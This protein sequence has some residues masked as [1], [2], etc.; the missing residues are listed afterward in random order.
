MK[1]QPGQPLPEFS[2]PALDGSTFHTSQLHGNPALINFFRFATCPF[3]NLRLNALLN[4]HPNLPPNFQMIAIFESPID[5]LAKHAPA[6]QSTIPVLANPE[7]DV[8]DLFGVERSVGGMLKGMATR[9]PTLL[10]GV[11]QGHI[12]TTTKGLSRMPAE[13][14]VHPDATLGPVYYGADDGDH[15]PLDTILDFARAAR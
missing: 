14:L 10:K 13:F 1:R 2:L 5:Y 4:L 7:C 15:M 11:S 8:Y 12:P 3:C 6:R 9:I